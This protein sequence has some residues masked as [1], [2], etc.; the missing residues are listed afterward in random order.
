MKRCIYISHTRNRLA[1]QD[2][3]DLLLHV[4]RRN[5]IE[6]I[7]GLLLYKS[8]TF[9]QVIEG[10]DENVDRVIDR[11]FHDP[12]HFKMKV[13]SEHPGTRRRFPGWHMGFRRLYTKPIAHESYFSLTRRALEARIPKG[14]AQELIMLLRSYGEAKLAA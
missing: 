2:L 9:F 3:D 6:Q 5:Q 13:L 14:A 8:K 1:E 10:P 7:T 4:W 12:R 11:V